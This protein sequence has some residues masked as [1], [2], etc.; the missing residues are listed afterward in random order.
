VTN[1]PESGS[2]KNAKA[3]SLGIPIID[4]KRFL[5]LLADPALAAE[6][7]PPPDGASRDT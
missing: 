5:E 1:D 4:E 7:S 6:S 2:A 3:R